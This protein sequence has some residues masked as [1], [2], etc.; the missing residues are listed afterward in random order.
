MAKPIPEGLHTVTPSLALEGAAEALAFYAKALGAV[1][2]M[3]APDPSG[4]KIWHAEFRIG[5]SIIFIND[6][7][8]E[9]GGSPSNVNLWIYSDDVDAA[10]KRAVDAGCTV[11]MPV[12]DMFWGDRVGSV[13]DKWGIHWTFAKHVKDMTPEE[14]KKAQDAFVASTKKG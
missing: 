11:R 14:M 1:E 7:F 13:G 10:F 6:V 4:K 12:A 2:T 3:R 9:M 5:D 8:P